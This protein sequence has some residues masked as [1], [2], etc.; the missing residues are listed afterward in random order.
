[1]VCAN[2]LVNVNPGPFFVSQ[3]CYGWK[4]LSLISVMPMFAIERQEKELDTAKG[5]HKIAGGTADEVNAMQNSPMALLDVGGTPFHTLMTT[6][7]ALL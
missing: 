1:M 7:S 5:Y 2:A 6:H 4:W 3:Y